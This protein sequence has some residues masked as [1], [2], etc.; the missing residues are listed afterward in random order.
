MKSVRAYGVAKYLRAFCLLVCALG[1]GAAQAAA[2]HYIV[3]VT[4]GTPIDT[5]AAKYQFSVIKSSTIPLKV[6]YSVTTVDQLSGT[7][8][9]NLLSEPG[10]LEVETN[11]TV[12]CAEEDASSLAS[13]SLQALGDLLSTHETLQYYGSVVLKTYVNQPGTDRIKLSDAQT[14]FGA[15]S[16]TVAIIDTGIDLQ[17]PALSGVLVPG[18]DFT[19]D[20]PDT[21]SE[22]LDVSAPLGSALQQSTVELLDSKQFI[23]ALQ[24]STVELLDQVTAASLN[25]NSPPAA[26]GHGT[27]VAGLVHLVSPGARIMPLKAF[28]ADGTALIVDVA[29]AIRYAVDHGA[30]IISMSF[31]YATPST[32]LES[33]I[34]YATSHNVL[35][36]ASAGNAGTETVMYP[37]GYRKVIGVGSVDSSDRRSP[38]SNSGDSVNTAAPGEALITLFPGGNYAAVWGTSF[39]SALVAG[40]ASLMMSVSPNMTP[41][42]LLQRAL[43][44][45]SPIDREME[46]G[47]ARLDLLRS[48]MY[49]LNPEN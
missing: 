49:L 35:C 3:E 30:G 40:G 27:M 41:G 42:V 2:A 4:P 33:A 15:G 14:R 17:H 21:V 26:F 29:D 5:L 28:N 37:A 10:V 16:A 36:I 38:F 44:A 12:E 18:Y 1:A 22:L 24:Q 48:L 7:D 13:Q 9:A 34:A 20:R 6:E 43:D 47:R 31:A 25:G 8:L 11:A 39:S 23:V 19:R 32:A 46:I 45:G